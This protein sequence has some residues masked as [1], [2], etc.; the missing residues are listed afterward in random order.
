MMHGAIEL[1]VLDLNQQNNLAF[2]NIV[3]C[4]NNIFLIMTIRI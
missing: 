3:L 2:H 1:C 4:D